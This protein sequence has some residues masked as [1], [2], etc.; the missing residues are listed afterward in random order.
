MLIRC[1]DFETTGLEPP[2]EV[3]EVGWCNMED[4]AAVAPCH[5]LCRIKSPM[6]PE[7]SAVHHL[8]DDD[9][10]SDIMPFF[11]PEAFVAAED[12]EETVFAAHN[13]KFERQWF[14]PPDAKW[15]D[16]YRCALR[17]WPAAPSHGLQVLRYYLGLNCDRQLA[18]PP[19]RAGPDAYVCAVLLE[20]MLLKATVETLIEWT[21]QPVLLSFIKFGKHKGAKFSELPLDYLQW[22]QRSD[23][24]KDEDIAFTV[25]AELK[26]RKK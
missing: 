20:R 6:P 1:I 26:R 3:C 23:L 25:A 16:T 7:A 8:T 11:R 19:H 2:A 14:N 17:M 10:R 24:M 4:G 18:S 15:I 13:A 12:D 5:I 9:L 21:E 22:M